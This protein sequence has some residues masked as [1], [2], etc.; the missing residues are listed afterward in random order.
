MESIYVLSNQ[1]NSV[2]VYSNV[3]LFTNR[4]NMLCGAFFKIPIFFTFATWWR[5]PL[6]LQTLTICHNIILR[7][8]EAMI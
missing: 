1:K 2:Y 7:S 8:K 6:I 4:Y 5:S 3:F